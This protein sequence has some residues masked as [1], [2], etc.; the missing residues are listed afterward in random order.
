M[1]EFTS[2]DYEYPLDRDPKALFPP[3]PKFDNYFKPGERVSVLDN[4]I[5][6]EHPGFRHKHAMEQMR[7]AMYVMKTRG[8]KKISWEPVDTNWEDFE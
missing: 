4:L 1:A 2:F 8:F 5:E 3:I 6:T 7:R